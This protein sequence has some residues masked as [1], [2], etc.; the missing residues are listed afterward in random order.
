ME[1]ETPFVSS[2]EYRRQFALGLDAILQNETLG[3]FIL[4]LANALQDPDI[5]QQLQAPLHQR[6]SE[7][8]RQYQA[9]LDADEVPAGINPED[10]NVFRQLRQMGMEHLPS[11][12]YR[13]LGPWQLQLNHLRSLRPKRMGAQVPEQ[14][15]IPFNQD[16]FHFNKPFMEKE[17]YWQGRIGNYDISCFYNKF[18]FI[19]G[20]L[21]L[22]PER[23]QQLPQ[24][25]RRDM[26]AMLWEWCKS[27]A[28]W[29]QK[30]GVVFN[31]AGAYASVNHLHYQMYLRDSSL[32]IESDVWSHAGG[33]VDYPVYCR[34]Y[35]DVNDAWTALEE[36]HAANQPYNLLY[37]PDVMYLIPRKRQ[38][39]YATAAWSPG[40]AWYETCGG[41]VVEDGDAFV[42]MDE[43]EVTAQLQE[44][45]V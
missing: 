29:E 44:L 42:T 33:D 21:L 7:L 5:W 17:K 34:T 28:S 10:V 9:I 23:Q 32:A 43:G 18:P 31:S 38:G 1:S 26:H 30:V 14:L 37:R 40:F 35:H 25:H 24:F 19:E 15:Y 6:F 2:E 20:H 8:V 36:L 13:Q 45:R 4:V 27:L 3:A 12:Q 11:I 39:S 22:V 16:G 41:F